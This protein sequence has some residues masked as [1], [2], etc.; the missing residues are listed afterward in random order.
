MATPCSHT[1][2]RRMQITSKRADPPG[3]WI[4]QRHCAAADPAP[5]DRGGD[6]IAQEERSVVW[7][8]SVPL[9]DDG[10][11]PLDEGEVV[12]VRDGQTVAI[13]GS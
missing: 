11:R 10:W 12:A 8:A 3:L 1:A 4:R 7:I 6:S 5:D 2:H 9:T 13:N